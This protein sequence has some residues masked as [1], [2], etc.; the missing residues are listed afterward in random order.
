MAEVHA[1]MTTHFYKP[2]G[3]FVMGSSIHILKG[4]NQRRYRSKELQLIMKTK[5]H[6]LIKPS[7]LRLKSTRFVIVLCHCTNVFLYYEFKNFNDI[8][9]GLWATMP[10]TE[11][12]WTFKEIYSIYN[13]ALSRCPLIL[14]VKKQRILVIHLHS[15]SREAY[16]HVQE[17]KICQERSKQG[18]WCERK[19]ILYYFGL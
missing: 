8:N 7:T 13:I 19:S 17:D 18:E 5:S 3:K 14:C 12:V 6:P 10:Y 9:I 2:S 4:I 16:E 15:K 11:L 1:S